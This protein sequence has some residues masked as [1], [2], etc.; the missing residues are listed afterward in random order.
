VPKFAKFSASVKQHQTKQ[1]PLG[2][3]QL[4]VVKTPPDG[5]CFYHAL[6]LSL[7]G[8]F[9]GSV[10]L[11][12]VIA[13]YIRDNWEQFKGFGLQQKNN[14]Y[15]MHMQNG[16]MATAVQVLGAA[17]ALRLCIQVKVRGKLQSYQDEKVVPTKT[18]YMAFSGSLDSGHFDAWVPLGTA[19]AWAAQTRGEDPDAPRGHLG[20]DG[21][22]VWDRRPNPGLTVAGPQSSSPRVL[23]PVSGKSQMSGDGEWRVVTRKWHNSELQK[24]QNERGSPP[25]TDDSE[26]PAEQRTVGPAESAAVPKPEKSCDT[27]VCSSDYEP[28]Q[29]EI[30]Q[31]LATW[32][33]PVVLSDFNLNFPIKIKIGGR[34]VVG[35]IDSEAK[36]SVLARHWCDIDK[37]KSIPLDGKVNFGQNRQEILGITWELVQVSAKIQGAFPLL[38]ADLPQEVSVVLGQDFLNKFC[39]QYARKS[40]TYHFLQNGY[41][42]SK[43]RS[44]TWKDK[45]WEILKVSDFDKV[46]KLFKVRVKIDGLQL[47]AALDLGA[48]RTILNSK[49]CTDTSALHPAKMK[50]RVANNTHLPVDGV[51]NPVITLGSVQVRHAIVVAPIPHDVEILIGND[52]MEK[53]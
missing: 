13:R 27:M 12:R 46:G 6:S 37:V 43:N 42:A 48:V 20:A 33:K 14:Y 30:L 1:D 28:E 50:L 18:V 24:L 51:Y 35:L 19:Q 38:I 16:E 32:K 52:F 10:A 21:T 15:A 39:G 53:I 47:K 22:G 11:R 17:A 2:L 4:V 29:I 3:G 25:M 49:F 41:L 40:D 44:K 7:F 34:T 23:S 26:R 9:N 45:E 5:S 31:D 36:Y 8:S